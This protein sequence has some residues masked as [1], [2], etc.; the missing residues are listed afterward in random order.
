MSA[1]I[2]NGVGIAQSVYRLR[3]ELDDRGSFPG[4]GNNGIFSSSLPRPDRL[5]DPSILLSSGYR[6]ILPQT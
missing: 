1:L 3:Y 4:G 5:L 2:I 6:G